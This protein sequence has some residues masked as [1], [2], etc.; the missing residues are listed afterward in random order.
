MYNC[1]ALV[2]YMYAV[3][4]H[5][6]NGPSY[7]TRTSKMCMWVMNYASRFAVREE[8]AA[9][10]RPKLVTSRPHHI[11]FFRSPG[12]TGVRTRT[13]RPVHR[14]RCSPSNGTTLA[15]YR[16]AVCEKVA[17][18]FFF[19]LWKVAANFF[20][21][22]ERRFGR[23][24][25]PVQYTDRE[26]PRPTVPPSPATDL[27]FGR[28]WLQKKYLFF[29]SPGPTEVRTMTPPRPVHRSRNS[30]SNGTTLARHRPAVREKVAFVFFDLPIQRRFGRWRHPVQYTD[31]GIPR[32]TVPPSPATDPPFG[33][34]WLQKIYPRKTPHV[35]LAYYYSD[36]SEQSMSIAVKYYTT[37]WNGSISLVG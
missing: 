29:R 37:A 26:I 3:R 11:G 10:F 17:A 15:G 30:P 31:R 12:R 14:S 9:P 4:G 5:G 24:R 25:H 21:P 18:I 16:P 34:K 23:W 32:P 13:P 27:P 36:Y 1:I 6:L 7:S 8:I 35:A 33:R 19:D 22:V 2:I 20:L 28:K